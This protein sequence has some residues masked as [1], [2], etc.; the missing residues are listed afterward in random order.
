MLQFPDIDPIAFSIGPIAVRWYALAY[1]T[2]FLL[3]WQYALYIT[4]LGKNSRPHKTEIDDFLPWA[5]LGVIVGG[6]LGYVLIYQ[7]ELYLAHPMEIPKLWHG[8]MSF[9]GGLLGAVTAMIAYSWY[10][11]IPLLR[12]SDMFACATPIGLFFGRIANFINGELFGRIGKVPWA[13]EFPGGGAV[14]RHPSQLY[15]AGLEGLL[16]FFILFFLVRIEA[17]RERPG[18]LSGIFLI[19]YGSSRMFVEQFR[20]PDAQIG[21]LFNL[22]SMGQ[23]LSVPMIIG[24]VVLVVYAL[25]KRERTLAA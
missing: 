6:R 23:L 17:I 10:E 3:G 21:L 14:P 2:A 9:H 7:P 1:L 5:I 11:K 13:M 20:E 22:F 25:I 19:G 15:E 18:L 4:G 16:L 8:G 12:L 24:G